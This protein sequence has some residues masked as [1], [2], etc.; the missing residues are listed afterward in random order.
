MTLIDT[1]S[2]VKKLLTLMILVWYKVKVLMIITID[3]HV[4][5]VRF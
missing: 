3:C 1:H 5:E 4:N 2:E